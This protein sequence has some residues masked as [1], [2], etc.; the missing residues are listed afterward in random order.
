MTGRG[1]KQRRVLPLL[2]GQTHVSGTPDHGVIGM[3]N[4]IGQTLGQYTVVKL[5]GEGGMAAV[6][7]AR[8]ESMKRDVAIKVIKTNL[9][10]MEDFVQRFEH[11]AQMVASL[12]HAHILKVFDYG[13]H[14]DTVYLV[15]EL[16]TGGSLDHLVK[17]GPLPVDRTVTLMEQIAGA[18]DYAH[19][20]GIIHRDLKP[21]NV[22]MDESGNAF[23]TD[24]GLAKLVNSSLKLTQSGA[25]MGTPAYMS[26]EQWKGLPL[27]ARADIYSLGILL[28]EMLSGSLPFEGDSVL[29]M[30]YMHLHEQPPALRVRNP[31]VSGAVEMVVERA[32]SKEPEDRFQSAGQMAETLRRAVQKGDVPAAPVRSA[33][34]SQPAIPVASTSGAV[35][36]VSASPSASAISAQPVQP[37]QA[38]QSTQPIMAAPR[39]SPWLWAIGIAALVVLIGLGAVGIARL[40][41]P[42]SPTAIPVLALESS[43][44]ENL[45]TPIAQTLSAQTTLTAAAIA[46]FTH[47]PTATPTQTSTATATNT[48]TDTATPTATATNTPTNTSTPVPPSDTPQPTLPPPPTQEPPTGPGGQGG[49]NG[50]G[51]QGGPNG[52]PGGGPPADV[53]AFTLKGASGAMNSV[54]FSPDGTLVA[55]ASDDM[56][57]Q[58]WSVSS[59]KLVRTFKGH[60]GAVK[61]VAFSPN[62]SSLLT[63]SADKTL[64][65][66]EM[67]TGKPIRTFT[68]HDD[69]VESVVFSLDGKY[70]LSASADKTAKLWDVSSG[71][72]VRTF[73]GSH[74]GT[75]YRA[76]FS[77]DGRSIV[78]VSADKTVVIWNVESGKALKT[79][80]G[81]SG[82]IRTV[83]FSPDG[84]SLVTGSEDGTAKVWNFQSGQLL[85]T[86][87]NQSPVFA[88][89]YTPDGRQLRTAGEDG[90]ARGWDVNSGQYLRDMT[91]R[92]ASILDAAFGPRGVLYF[93]TAVSDHTVR[94]WKLQRPP[95]Q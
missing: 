20:K 63:G 47:T 32:L 42:P 7:Q 44:T 85:Q 55:G 83:A 88:V 15:M 38:G 81:H 80:N 40:V 53:A 95:N 31:D 56:T 43:A 84:A 92:T 86:L 37:T 69:T 57:I 94:L 34:P 73:E 4:L 79:L 25:A 35:P 66:W 49:P 2:S 36:A 18:L 14:E 3:A 68:G 70:A 72:L 6:Y 60:T 71:D 50:P 23:L 8:Q 75:I 10:E 51:G 78:T 64:I 12:S 46:S 11:E 90:V 82:A 24:F 59:G 93:V 39:Q 41:A 89:T 29:S 52:L 26:P 30:M 67:A 77:S 87:N 62:G 74:T 45:E 65:L 9:V 27:D 5:I 13:R 91:T 16:L 33:A 19:Q 61:S 1:L 22:M 17:Q 58:L 76:I 28:Y 54:V 21:E 48:A